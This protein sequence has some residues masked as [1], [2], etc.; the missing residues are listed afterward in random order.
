M[1]VIIATYLR[2]DLAILSAKAIR[3]FANNFSSIILADGSGKIKDCDSIDDI[4]YVPFN[5]NLAI[6]I[7]REKFK[8]ESF[9]CID[10]DV[11][12]VNHL[13]LNKYCNT[14]YIY[15]PDNGFM[16]YIYH[17]EAKQTN[18]LSCIRLNYSNKNIL[19]Y[20]WLDLAINNN[21]ELIDKIWLHID[22]GSETPIRSRIEIES[23]L[24][25]YIEN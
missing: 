10:D 18:I 15:Q 1:K 8:N 20:P 21:C 19:N 5:R 16:V 4:L 9:I 25:N 14:R 13:D 3:K 17:P 11:I 23:A 6:S 22:K 24:K 12:L 2:K 7:L